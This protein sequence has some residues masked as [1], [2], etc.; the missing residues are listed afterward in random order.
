M[1]VNAVS[2]IGSICAISNVIPRDVV[3]EINDTHSVMSAL[4]FVLCRVPGHHSSEDIHFREPRVDP[5]LQFIFEVHDVPPGE[6]EIAVAHGELF[7]V[8]HIELG[9]IA[10]AA[11]FIGEPM[12]EVHS[13]RCRIQTVAPSVL[14]CSFCMIF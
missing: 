13:L 7:D 10:I 5:A 14:L 3:I 1:I 6:F 2:V 9:P 11:E 4:L 12:Y 8:V